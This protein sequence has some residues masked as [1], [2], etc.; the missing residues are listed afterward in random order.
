MKVTITIRRFDN[1]DTGELTELINRSNFRENRV[2]TKTAAEM[3]EFL[4]EPGEEIRENTFVAIANNR[5]VGYNAL[6]FVKGD[7][8]FNVY[9]YGTVDP[10]F[11]RQGIGSMLVKESLCHLQQRAEKER[12]QINYN[13]MARVETAGQIPLAE[14]FGFTK[15]TDLLLMKL[16]LDIFKPMKLAKNDLVFQTVS[17]ADAAAWADIYNDAFSWSGKHTDLSPK[18]VKYEF[19]SSE[20]SPDFYMLCKNFKRDALG[21]VCG[22]VEEEGKGVISTLAVSKAF[23]GKGVGKALLN[24]ILLRMKNIGLKEVRLSVDDKNPTAAIHLYRKAGFNENRR[25]IQYVYELNP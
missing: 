1:Q 23:Q 15:Y 4:D 2:L 5:I 20:F 14:K 24:E 22:S 13:Q 18:N 11:R 17:E 8:L 21:F 25:I 7:A 19:W 6:C 12:I 10:E 3:N 16:D 9:S